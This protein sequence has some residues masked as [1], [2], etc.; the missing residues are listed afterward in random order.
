MIRARTDRFLAWG[1]AGALVFALAAC[2]TAPV[3][4]HVRLG[5]PSQANPSDRRNYLVVRPQYVLSFNCQTGLANWAAWQVDRRYLGRTDR[6]DDFERDTSLPAGCLSSA[7][8]AYR[9]SGYDRGHLVPSA[10]RSDTVADNQATFLTSNVVPQSP[11]NNRG[12]W[13]ELEEY[14]L[15]LIHISEPTRPY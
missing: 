3:S 14:C 4:P 11:A 5:N 6:Q 1:L 12:P 10:D 9:G 2:Q 8:Q 7:P 15:S 13:R